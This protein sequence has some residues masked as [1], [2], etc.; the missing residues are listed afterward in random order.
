MVLVLLVMPE[1]QDVE[2]VMPIKQ[3]VRLATKEQE[4]LTIQQ[5]LHALSVL[6]IVQNVQVLQ[7]ELHQLK[8]VHKPKMVIMLTLIKLFKNVLILLPNVNG[9]L[10]LLLQQ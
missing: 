8:Y 2:L 10:L 4:I 3:H 7:L 9:M 6:E 5:Q 1:Q